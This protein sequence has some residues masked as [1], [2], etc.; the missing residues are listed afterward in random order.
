MGLGFLAPSDFG[1]PDHL[2]ITNYSPRPGLATAKNEERRALVSL[3]AE[4]HKNFINQFTLDSMYRTLLVKDPS[5]LTC[6]NEVFG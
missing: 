5:F 6:L 1:L 3:A 4:S 2:G